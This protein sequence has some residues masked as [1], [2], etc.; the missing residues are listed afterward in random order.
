M[1]SIKKTILFCRVTQGKTV[2]QYPVATF[3]G[4]A[5][6]KSYATMLHLAYTSQNADML[7]SL[8]PGFPIDEGGKLP[9]RPAWS[10][11]EVPYEPVA[12]LG[13]IVEEPPVPA[14]AT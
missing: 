6:A 1:K 3:G 8:D 14:P 5:S 12:E 9:E 7:R 4:P 10:L 13:S 2:H 11:T